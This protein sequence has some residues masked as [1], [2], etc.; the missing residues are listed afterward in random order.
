VKTLS[1]SP[2]MVML[3]SLECS[4]CHQLIHGELQMSLN[5]I[6]IEGLAMC[7]N[8]CQHVSRETQSSDSYRRRWR[9]RVN[10][11]TKEKGWGWENEPKNEAFSGGFRKSG[12]TLE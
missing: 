12:G 10:A 1:C 9:R 2:C 8:C 7:P 3:P 11:I 6:L 5:V 4:L